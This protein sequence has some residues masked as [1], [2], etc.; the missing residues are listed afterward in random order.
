MHSLTGTQSASVGPEEPVEDPS[1]QDPLE[2][3]SV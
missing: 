1:V 3:P 2:D